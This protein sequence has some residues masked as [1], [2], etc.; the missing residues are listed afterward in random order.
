MP[1]VDSPPATFPDLPPNRTAASIGLTPTELWIQL[2]VF[3]GLLGGVIPTVG[4]VA[5]AV[6]IVKCSNLRSR[7]FVILWYLVVARA[8]VSSQLL[9]MFV[10]RLLRTLH[11]VDITM[12]RLGCYFIHLNTYYALTVEMILLLG[13]VLDRTLAVVAYNY[14]RYLTIRHAIVGCSVASIMA[15]IMK[16]APS[17]YGI[18]ALQ[19][20]S[21]VNGYSATAAMYNAYHQHVDLAI[22]LLILVLYV[23]LLLYLHFRLMPR[24]KLANQTGDRS[25]LIAFKRQIKLL[26][27]LRML[28]LLHCGF[29]LVSKTLLSVS[30]LVPEVVALRLVA[31]GG[32]INTVDLSSNVLVLLV[33][34]KDLRK[35]VIPCFD[36]VVEPIHGGVV[37]N[38]R[39]RQ[40]GRDGQRT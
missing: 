21:C 20:I 17:F 6:G 9:V 15:I 39:R 13:L 12:T 30:S 35:A 5:I 4:N 37:M 33:Y 2:I 23:A 3:N 38:E 16:M 40:D 32:M 24:M 34:N 36:T 18:D 31:Y 19:S 7:F 8:L 27:V 11:L 26:P 22:A 10:Y 1:T 25:G 14:Y 28:V 29:A